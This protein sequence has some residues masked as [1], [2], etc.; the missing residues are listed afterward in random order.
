MY[1]LRVSRERITDKIPMG[2][3]F[4]HFQIYNFE[5]PLL[6]K[7]IY[8]YIVIHVAYNKFNYICAT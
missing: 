3:F 7:T 1:L 4:D 8:K 2:L 5:D 6:Y